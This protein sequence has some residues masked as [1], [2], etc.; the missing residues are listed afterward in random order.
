MG[1]LKRFSFLLYF[2]LFLDFGKT[3][4]YLGIKFLGFN[5]T[6]Y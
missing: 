4:F 5:L 6:Y 1:K 3:S 2:I